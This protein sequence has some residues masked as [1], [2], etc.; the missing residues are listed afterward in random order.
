[1]RSLPTSPGQGFQSRLKD[2]S[3]LFYLSSPR[4]RAFTAAASRPSRLCLFIP[5]DLP[6]SRDILRG[7]FDSRAVKSRN[8]GEDLTARTRPTALIGHISTYTYT[9]FAKHKIIRWHA[10]PPSFVREQKG[11]GAIALIRTGSRSRPPRRVIRNP[12][13]N[14]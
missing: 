10:R 9:S 5:P 2:N 12:P 1:M 11:R 13:G 7:G 6:S 8:L 3:M 14:R 4:A